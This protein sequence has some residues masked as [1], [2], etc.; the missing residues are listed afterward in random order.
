MKLNVPT[1]PVATVVAFV[2]S[3]PDTILLA[4]FVR[5][6]VSQKTSENE[7]TALEAKL[8]MLLLSHTAVAEG[9]AEDV[10]AV[11]GKVDEATRAAQDERIVCW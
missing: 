5:S 10:D 1:I 4:S 6:T 8:I 9:A 7:F 11:D 2:R 3:A